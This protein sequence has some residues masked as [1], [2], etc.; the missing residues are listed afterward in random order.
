[1]TSTDGGEA[2]FFPSAIAYVRA[3]FFSS[4]HI[5]KSVHR[6]EDKES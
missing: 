2:T 5:F 6:Q 1:M 3:T 4:L